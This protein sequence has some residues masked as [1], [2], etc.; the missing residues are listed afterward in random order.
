M[1]KQYLFSIIPFSL[2]IACFISYNI[3]GSEIT[4]DGTLVEPFGLIPLGYLFF[5]IAIIAL[6]IIIIKKKK[7]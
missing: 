1:K 2:G 7:Q 6:I 4:Q 3:I 5:F